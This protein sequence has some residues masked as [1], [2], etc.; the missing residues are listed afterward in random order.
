[1]TIIEKVMWSLPAQP[2]Q[3]SLNLKILSRRGTHTDGSE[4]SLNHQEQPN[5][6]LAMDLHT[7]PDQSNSQFL[8]TESF[9][10]S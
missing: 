9:W 4:P 8:R 10:R 5:K 7:T 2:S 1:M 6:E 3:P